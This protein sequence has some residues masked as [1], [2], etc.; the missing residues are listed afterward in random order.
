M[1]RL[2]ATALTRTPYA[3]ASIAAQRVSAITP[4][5]AAA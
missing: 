4:A 2:G 3:A 1:A 5:L